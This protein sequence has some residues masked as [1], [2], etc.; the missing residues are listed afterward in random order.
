MTCFEIVAK[1]SCEISHKRFTFD[2]KCM[3]CVSFIAIRCKIEYDN[4]CVLKRK[5]GVKYDFR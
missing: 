4:V 5:M 3:E 1:H 2:P